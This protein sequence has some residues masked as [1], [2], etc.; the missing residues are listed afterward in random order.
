MKSNAMSKSK[1][2]WFVA[3]THFDCNMKPDVSILVVANNG[4]EEVWSVDLNDPR[5]KLF[6]TEEAAKA[7]AYSWANTDMTVH[8]RWIE[9][10]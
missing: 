8:G 9:V 10:E 2:V 7:V 5:I 4:W 3:K 1:L 6:E